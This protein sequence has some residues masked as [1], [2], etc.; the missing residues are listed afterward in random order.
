M[1]DL[2]APLHPLLWLLW[3]TPLLL[4]AFRTKKPGRHSAAHFPAQPTP[5]ELSPSIWLKPWTTPPSPHITE[6]NEPF[7]DELPDAVR[8][9]IAGFPPP[10]TKQEWQHERCR[11]AAFAAAGKE[12][13]YSYPGAPIPAGVA[14]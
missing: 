4:L 2:I 6:R 13:P 8:P 1:R 7:E 12:Y 10:R 11:A 5:I 9:Y 3:A 14:L